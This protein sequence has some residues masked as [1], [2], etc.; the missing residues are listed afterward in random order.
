MLK[1]REAI[2]AM[3][4]TPA[5]L[6]SVLAAMVSVA[7]IVFV[8][9][10]GMS[11]ESELPDE[12]KKKSVAE[13]NFRK[14]M[15]VAIFSGLMSSAMSFGLQGGPGIQKLALTVAPA[16][17]GIWAGM[18]DLVI[19]LLGG[20]LVNGSWCIF[21]NVRNKTGGDYVAGNA[22]VV[23]NLALAGIAGAV[24]CSQF[25]AFKTGEPR[26]GGTSY[27]GWAVLM[28]STILFSQL[29]GVLLGE[30]R[31]ASKKTVRLL[32]TGLILLLV[33]AGVAGYSG[34]MVLQ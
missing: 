18:P 24:W 12:E 15:T 20:F 29:L 33:S 11:K 5:G 1:G 28:A 25:I 13:F 2:Q 34:S 26:M 21:L 3:F 32:L 31:G 10:A 17:S 7:G 4:T 6:V 14:G 23:A 8:G 22:P 16:T 30:W 27:I 9:M 19:V